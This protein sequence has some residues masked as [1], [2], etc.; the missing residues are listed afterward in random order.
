MLRL[1]L[2]TSDE[3]KVMLYQAS[4]ENSEPTIEIPK[5]TIRMNP[6]SG[7]CKSLTIFEESHQDCVCQPLEKLNPITMINKRISILEN[8]KIF[9]I[10]FPCSTPRLL[11]QV[12][13]T[14][15]SMAI[16]CAKLILTE[17]N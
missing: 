16:S 15:D 1:G 12:N 6:S 2:I 10:F 11:I 8:V 17:P 3:A 7:I 4:D 14:I 5:A 9:W 13:N